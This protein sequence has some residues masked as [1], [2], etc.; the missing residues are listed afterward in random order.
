MEDS[1]GAFLSE[2]ETKLWLPGLGAADPEV[3]RVAKAV[4]A[5]DPALR[6]AKHEVTGDWVICIGDNGHPVFGFGRGLP[7]PEDVAGML[8]KHD[9]KRNGKR[10]LEALE[11]QRQRDLLDSQY[12][13]SEGDEAS[14]EAAEWFYNKHGARRRTTVY[15]PKG[16]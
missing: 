2:A 15:V 7:N 3:R 4:D 11:K 14:A 12:R 6:L 16:V 1:T 13:V 9:V 5:Y 10:I 8:A